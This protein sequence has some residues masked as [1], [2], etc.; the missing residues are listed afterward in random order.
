MNATI[1]IT[2]DVSDVIA[3]KQLSYLNLK[4]MVLTDV[5]ELIGVLRALGLA[6]N[7]YISNGIAIVSL[8]N[9]ILV[10]AGR[11]SYLAVGVARRSNSR[12]FIL[13]NG[14][15]VGRDSTAAAI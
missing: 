10:G 15:G 9:K 7:D 8:D 3:G 5:L 13:L 6:I 14:N 12:A 11:N 1:R 2:L 4:S